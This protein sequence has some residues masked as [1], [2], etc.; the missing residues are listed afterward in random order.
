[1]CVQC[2]LPLN[3]QCVWNCYFL[4]FASIHRSFETIS[5][6]NTR[7]NTNASLDS[8][9]LRLWMGLCYW[10]FSR[11]FLLSPAKTHAHEKIKWEKRK[12]L[13]PCNG[14]K[15]CCCYYQK[16][17]CA[18]YSVILVFCSGRAI[19][20][21]D[22]S[23]FSLLSHKT[24]ARQCLQYFGRLVSSKSL[25]LHSFFPPL[26]FRRRWHLVWMVLHLT[27]HLPG[28]VALFSHKLN[29]LM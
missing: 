26:F 8:L 10:G 5:N 27:L 2:A 20:L 11:F 23:H 16:R 21:P 13:F 17:P 6:F 9:H 18:L 25:R 29:A 7:T 15:F 3:L 24:F 28:V 12:V 14:I 19:S 1:M 22:I 4:F